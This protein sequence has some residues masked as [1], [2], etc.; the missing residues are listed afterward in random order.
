[1]CGTNG[2]GCILYDDDPSPA[3]I[4]LSPG[5]YSYADPCP[6]VEAG[7]CPDCGSPLIGSLD[8]L[9]T[10][11]G[12]YTDELRCGGEEGEEEGCGWSWTVALERAAEP[13]DYEGGLGDS[14]PDD[15]PFLR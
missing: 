13:P 8:D 12:Q 1:M 3:G 14:W 4:S 10:E 6:C 9:N 7:K 5:T 2:S 15:D 11:T